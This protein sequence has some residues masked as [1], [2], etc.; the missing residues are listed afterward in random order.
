MP[1]QWLFLLLILCR[2]CMPNPSAE[3]AIGSREYRALRTARRRR[4]A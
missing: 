2:I 3:P 4:A 1:L